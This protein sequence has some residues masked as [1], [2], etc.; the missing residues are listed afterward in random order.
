M[1]R[2]N[3]GARARTGTAASKER[4]ATDYPTPQSCSQH[5]PPRYAA[6]VNRPLTALIM[7]A[8]QGTR[9]R[10]AIPK[11][12]HQVCG[13]PMLHWVIEAARGA[14]ADRVV[15][16]TRPGEGVAEGRT[17][18]EHGT[19]GA[20]TVEQSGAAQYGQ[21]VADRA[22]GQSEAPCELGRAR[23]LLQRHQQPRR[24]LTFQRRDPQIKV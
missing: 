8:G 4:W 5:R 23:R 2:T 19:A 11:V 18:I 12:L 16:V 1:E 14:G 15:C 9:M 22:G 24:E 7:A 13:R 6:N 3:W 21:V 20:C 17:A 10:S